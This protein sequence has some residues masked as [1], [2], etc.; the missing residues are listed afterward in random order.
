M[1]KKFFVD[2]KKF[3]LT[4]TRNSNST[5][6]KP[7]VSKIHTAPLK[8]RHGV[9]FGVAVSPSLGLSL[10]NFQ[11]TCLR[12]WR[13]LMPNFTPNGEVAAEKPRTNKNEKRSSY[14]NYLVSFRSLW[15]DNHGS[16][17]VHLYMHACWRSRSPRP[18]KCAYCLHD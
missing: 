15:M 16:D 13:C 4:R 7:R 3:E 10:Q 11:K 9:M 6:L 14:R 18:T 1:G 8:S 2:L 12:Y 17:Q 5:I